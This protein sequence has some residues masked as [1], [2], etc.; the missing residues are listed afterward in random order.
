MD[1]DIV[2]GEEELDLLEAALGCRFHDRRQ[3]V[4]ALT[5]RSHSSERTPDAASGD[6]E[7][8]EFLGDAVLGM[9]V[10][11]ELVRGFPDWSEGQLSK[12]RARFVNETS[13]AG[14][15]RQLD[16][17]RHL[18]L[19]RGEEKTGGRQKS[20]LLADAFEAVLA[21]IYLDSGLEAAT[22]FVR[23]VLLTGALEIEA[24]RRGGSDFKS[25]LQEGLQAQGRPPATYRVVEEK[26]PDHRKVF[27]VEVRAG[28]V[29]ATGSGSNKKEAEQAAARAIL[30]MMASSPAEK[31]A[32]VE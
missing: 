30:E 12:S 17:G 15:A 21:A 22:N 28:H 24:S 27:L 26:G 18:R 23:R 16:F 3:L 32:N 11:A 13:L 31:S 2:Q 29:V 25:S 4:Q 19:G 8:L 14:A 9:I 7:K 20:A 6:N 10:S 1:P 5:H